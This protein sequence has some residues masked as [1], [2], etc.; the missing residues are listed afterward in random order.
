M[1]DIVVRSVTSVLHRVLVEPVDFLK[2]TRQLKLELHVGRALSLSPA[3][4][5]LRSSSFAL[6]VSYDRVK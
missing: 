3:K 6:C 2:S 5:V 4:G 1:P